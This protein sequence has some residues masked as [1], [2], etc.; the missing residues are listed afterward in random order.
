MT[1]GRFI[2]F[3]PDPRAR[4]IDLPPHSVNDSHMDLDELFAKRPDDPLT[5]LCKQDLDPLSV[6]DLR[7]R[8]GILAGEIARVNAKLDGAVKFR[9]S[10]DALFKAGGS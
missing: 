3:A 2:A 6:E 1:A 10:A 5:L 9:A 7:E 4:L 8:A